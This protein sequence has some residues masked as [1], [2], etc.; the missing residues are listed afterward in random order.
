MAVEVTELHQY[1]DAGREESTITIEHRLFGLV[2]KIDRETAKRSR[3]YVVSLKG[4]LT[5]KEEQEIL[6]EARNHILASNCEPLS[7][8][9][10]GECEVTQL[11]TRDTAL[12]WVIMV[13]G[14]AKTP[15]GN[16]MLA[17]IQGSVDY[18][19]GRILREKVPRLSQFAHWKKRVLVIVSKYF[20]ADSDNVRIGLQRRSGEIAPV[21]EIYL[22]WDSSF[23]I[24]YP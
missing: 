3:G 2:K 4:R 7:I 1:I 11:K 12:N 22:V 8:G 10:K 23:E 19:L 13:D 17:D 5:S 24:V 6:A 15:D 14:T 18:A 21:D 9:E 16:V 20:F